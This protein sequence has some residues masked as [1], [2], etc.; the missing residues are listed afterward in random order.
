MKLIK[1]I[2]FGKAAIGESGNIKA[3]YK[4]TYPDATLPYNQW[5][6]YISKLIK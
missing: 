4:T 5:Q 6:L 1:T 3:A 2:L